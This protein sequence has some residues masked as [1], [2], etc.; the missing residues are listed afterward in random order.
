MSGSPHIDEAALPNQLQLGLAAIR[1][2]AVPSAA[3]VA[4]EPNFVYVA[5]GTLSKGTQQAIDGAAPGDGELPEKYTV[6]HAQLFARVARNFPNAGCYGV[7]T[8]PFLRRS[9][10]AEIPWQH[11]NHASAQPV[12]T[13]LNS[14]DV[15]FW[16]W[17]WRD[18]PARQGEDLVAVVEWARKCVR[19]GAQ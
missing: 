8:V 14:S 9:D 18:M 13:A 7:V 12:A 17:D 3:V 1:A 15:G 16:S 11:A 10:G 4:A 6:N 2:R 5:V 19:D